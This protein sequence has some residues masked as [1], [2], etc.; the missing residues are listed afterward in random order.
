MTS[1]L[2]HRRCMTIIGASVPHRCVTLIMSC[3]CL[4]ASLTHSAHRRN[5]IDD[6][7][8][9]T[10]STRHLTHVRSSHS[11]CA[12]NDTPIACMHTASSHSTYTSHAHRTR[13]CATT[14]TRT[15]HDERR[16]SHTHSIILVHTH[17]HEAEEVCYDVC[18]MLLLF[19]RARAF[20]ARAAAEL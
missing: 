5:L 13:R 7:S 11:Q 17:T 14:H 12:C 18:M 16:T 2:T 15:P 3:A 6:H 10:D 4:T 1:S 19:H 9:T 8:L 20:S